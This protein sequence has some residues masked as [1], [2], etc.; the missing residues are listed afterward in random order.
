MTNHFT[1]PEQNQHQKGPQRKSISR[2]PTALPKPIY[3][4]PASL[5]FLCLSKSLSCKLKQ[6]K[7]WA[8]LGLRLLCLTP[9]SLYW[10]ALKG[11]RAELSKKTR[12]WLSELVPLLWNWTSVWQFC[13]TEPFP[14]RWDGKGMPAQPH[15]AER[16]S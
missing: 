8:L 13:C 2:R 11:W 9:S 1:V 15:K 5:F 3:Q 12:Q 6:D 14:Y 10:R 4:P 7:L 16:Q